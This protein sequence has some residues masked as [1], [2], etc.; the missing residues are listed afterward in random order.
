[1]KKNNLYIELM[2]QNNRYLDDNA[3][4]NLVG[5]YT[6]LLY[7][8]MISSLFLG[9]FLAVLNLFFISVNKL[10]LI[11]LTSLII[12]YASLYSAFKMIKEKTIPYIFNNP[13]FISAIFFTA[14]FNASLIQLL[15]NFTNLNFDIRLIIL[16]LSIILNYILLNRSFNKH[17]K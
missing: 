11:D 12:G 1:M 17:Y 2:N 10:S 4:F 15:L 5:I 14:F 13:I 9:A 3:S 8:I 7:T 6:K 16:V